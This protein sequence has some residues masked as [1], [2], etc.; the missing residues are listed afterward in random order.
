MAI[1]HTLAWCVLALALTVGPATA[2]A[3]GK[4][5]IG[6][7]RTI[8]A[9]VGETKGLRLMSNDRKHL[10]WFWL[11]KPKAAIALALPTEMLPENDEAVNGLSGRT[12]V[13]VTG[14][15]TGTTSALLGY[16]TADK[17][18]LLKTVVLHITI[19]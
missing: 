17:Q 18:R 13:Y 9:Q 3:T 6:L 19:H 14:R 5:E 10:H 8:D 4:P 1:Q 15:S 2:M 7:P 11:R 16:F 12:G